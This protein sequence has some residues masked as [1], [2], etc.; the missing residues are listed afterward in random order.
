[1]IG[2]M[3]PA[4]VPPME[5]LESRLCMTFAPKLHQRRSLGTVD[6]SCAYFPHARR[7]P[8]GGRRGSLF[9]DPLPGRRGTII[10]AMEPSSVPPMAPLE[11]AALQDLC[12]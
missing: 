10:G 11:L 12:G 6:S 9:T 2:A 4:S 3:K 1:M 5:P 7:S 8:K